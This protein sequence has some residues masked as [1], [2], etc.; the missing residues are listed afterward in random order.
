M[1][2]R[3]KGTK[4][5][6]YS[7]TGKSKKNCIMINIAEADALDRHNQSYNNLNNSFA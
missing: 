4:K 1:E 6:V 5:T 7:P 2:D 3:K